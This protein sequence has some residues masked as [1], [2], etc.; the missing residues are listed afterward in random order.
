MITLYGFMQTMRQHWLYLCYD[1]P[2]LLAYL[3][4]SEAGLNINAFANGLKSLA[5]CQR[6]KN[7]DLMKS[8]GEMHRA[9]A[10]H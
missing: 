9:D 5:D 4:L 10:Q 2:P 8:D 6:T 1:S 7:S 3:L